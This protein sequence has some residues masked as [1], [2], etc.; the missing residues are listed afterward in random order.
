MIEMQLKQIAFGCSNLDEYRAL[1]EKAPWKRNDFLKYIKRVAVADGPVKASGLAIVE[2]CNEFKDQFEI[3]DRWA[4]GHLVVLPGHRNNRWEGVWITLESMETENDQVKLVK[5]RWT[6][7][8]I[9]SQAER[10]KALA[11]KCNS[12]FSELRSVVPL[13]ETP[14]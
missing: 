14:S 5:N 7:F 10:A 1:K 8:Q 9:E 2:I 13:Q 4:H 6:Y 11:D 3:R 12:V